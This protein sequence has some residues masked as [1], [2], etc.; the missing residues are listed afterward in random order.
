MAPN[1]ILQDGAVFNCMMEVAG[2]KARSEK[3]FE[4]HAK[5]S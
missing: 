5:A 1:V 2:K 3:T 4:P